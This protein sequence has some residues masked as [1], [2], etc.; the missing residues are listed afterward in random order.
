MNSDL[1][2]HAYTIKPQEKLQTLKL[3]SIP[4]DTHGQAKREMH[5][6]TQALGVCDPARPLSGSLRVA[7]PD[8]Y[9]SQ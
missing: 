4:G 7:G 1:V 9:P 8:W 3:R 6:K 2:S 5:R